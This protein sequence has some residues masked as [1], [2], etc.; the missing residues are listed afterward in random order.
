MRGWRR[1]VG[2][3]R[4]LLIGAAVLLVLLVAYFGGSWVFSSKLIGQHFGSD[5]QAQFADFKL[6]QP[7]AVTLANGKAKLAG[8]YFA[9][10][11]AGTAKC[12]VVMLHGLSINK[13][14]V[15]P[16]TPMFWDRGCDLYL[17]DLRRHGES[18]EEFSTYGVHDKKDELIAVDWLAKRTGLP[19]ERIGLWGVS[20]GAATSLQAAAERPDLAFVVAEAS[21]ASLSDIAS[22][23]AG[24]IFGS[25]AKI[26]VPGALLVSGWRAGF[27]PSQASPEKA[28][29]GLETPVLLIHS[30]SDEF[31]P[32]QQSEKIY[33][34]SDHAHT[35]L[36]LTRWGAPHGESYLTD[37]LAYTRIVDNFLAKYVPNFGS[38]QAAA[39]PTG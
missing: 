15:V 38:R 23:Q 4:R 3:R 8:W 1:L 35:V 16:F 12:A 28:V 34:R 32:Y 31:T 33:A 26:F 6:P 17:Y 25:W 13:A 20:Y 22:F 9:N 30:T 21:Y 39:T 14:V 19:D 2:G 5:E 27:D 10:P 18:S 7:E 36:A 24:K 29:R 37:P 11:R